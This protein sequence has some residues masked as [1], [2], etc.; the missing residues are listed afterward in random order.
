MRSL[1]PKIE[2]RGE[3]RRGCNPRNSSKDLK[4]FKDSAMKDMKQFRAVVGKMSGEQHHVHAHPAVGITSTEPGRKASPCK[5]G[6]RAR[7]R[8]I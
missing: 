8:E 2:W 6:G 3:A 4:A 5:P 1:D 7:P